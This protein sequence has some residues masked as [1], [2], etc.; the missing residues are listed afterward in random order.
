MTEA[1]GGTILLVEDE[2]FLRSAISTLLRHNHY[3]VLEAGDGTI[4]VELLRQCPDKIDLVLLDATLPGLSSR[5]VLQ[6][7]RRLRPGMPIIITS[8]LDTAGADAFLN[9]L[10]GDHF[11]RKPYRLATLL[12]SVRTFAGM[13]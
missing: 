1:H 3:S 5:D 10:K 12:E 9:G 4:A 8:A 6:E 11:M 2:E 13:R 7:A